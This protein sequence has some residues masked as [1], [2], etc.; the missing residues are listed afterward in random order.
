MAASSSMP[1]HGAAPS[2]L[3]SIRFVTDR[4]LHKSLVEKSASRSRATSLSGVAVAPASPPG[5]SSRSPIWPVREAVKLTME[6]NAGADAD[7]KQRTAKPNV[8]PR[9][10]MSSC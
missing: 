7:V 9:S 6:F 4:T 2:S 8:C 5:W 10:Q 3:V 1:R